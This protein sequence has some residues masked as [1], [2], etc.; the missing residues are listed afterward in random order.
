MS[1][2]NSTEDIAVRNVFV[3]G[4]ISRDSIK[5]KWQN[6]ILIP[7]CRYLHFWRLYIFW[8]AALSTEESLPDKHCQNCHNMT[9]MWQGH[10]MTSIL[11]TIGCGKCVPLA[12]T[13]R[14][15]KE[16][17]LDTCHCMTSM[18]SMTTSLHDKHALNSCFWCW[19][20][21][22]LSRRHCKPRHNAVRE[23]DFNL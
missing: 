18:T 5:N 23:T 3:H 20:Q 22:Q 6:Q 11:S 21:H 14:N 9:I 19:G 4:T 17:S 12:K 2:Y 10:C 15:M 7:R 13:K 8:S 1:N 16:H